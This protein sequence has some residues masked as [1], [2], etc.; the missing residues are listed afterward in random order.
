MMRLVRCGAAVVLVGMMCV[1]AGAKTH[2]KAHR[3]KPLKVQIAE[4]L[5]D[6]AVAQ[7]HWGIA[8]T[9]M[10][11][12][13]IYSMNEGQLFQPASNAKLFTTV[14]ATALLGSGTTYETKVVGKGVFDGAER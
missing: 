11:G 12:A 14:A 7:A 9:Q 1:P 10:D 8:V 5:A 6:P 13:P 2:R 4:L 3:V